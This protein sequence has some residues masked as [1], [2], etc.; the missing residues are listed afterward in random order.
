MATLGIKGLTTPIPRDF[1]LY[2][3]FLCLYNVFLFPIEAILQRVPLSFNLDTFPSGH[4]QR[5]AGRLSEENR[6][7]APCGFVMYMCI[8]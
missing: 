8:V 1:W 4:V 5:F 3:K 7:G 2:F 6:Q